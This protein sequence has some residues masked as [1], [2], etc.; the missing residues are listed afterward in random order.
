MLL[1]S[2]RCF[3]LG[4]S[5]GREGPD[6]EFE[7]RPKPADELSSDLAF[8]DG[9][10]SPGNG[11][12]MAGLWPRDGSGIAGLSVPCQRFVAPSR[13]LS[14][15]FCLNPSAFCL[16]IS[17]RSLVYPSGPSTNVSAIPGQTLANS[18]GV[19]PTRRASRPGSFGSGSPEFQLTNS[20]SVYAPHIKGKVLVCLGADDAGIP[21]E[22]R[23]VF[24]E[25]MRAGKVDWQMTVYGGV[26]HSFTNPEADKMGQPDHLRYDAEADA[27]SWLQMQA[28]LQ[29]AFGYRGAPRDN[30]ATG[31]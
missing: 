2:A 29:E 23:K 27:R 28:L 30:P 15:A 12:L 6:I 7:L 1:L 18:L 22:Q 14:A 25:E 21:V 19:Q 10:L 4:T 24:E 11:R 20:K 16:S 8:G 5:R 9:V 31:G 17:S 13:P 3:R 26:V